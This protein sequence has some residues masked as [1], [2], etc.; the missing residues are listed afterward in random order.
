MFGNQMKS[1]AKISGYVRIMLT[2]DSLERLELMI[3]R[4]TA[5]TFKVQ[6]NRKNL[7]HC[8]VFNRVFSEPNHVI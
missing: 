6:E 7:T 4:M 2:K 3:M 5:T 1:L 8:I